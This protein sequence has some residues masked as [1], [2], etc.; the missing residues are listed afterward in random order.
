[1]RTPLSPL[2]AGLV[3]ALGGAA[4]GATRSSAPPAAGVDAAATTAPGVLPAAAAVLP[5]AAPAPVAG[6]WVTADY[7]RPVPDAAYASPSV[8]GV[9]LRL[10]WSEVHPSSTAY[11]WAYLDREIDRARAAGKRVS[12]AL[13]AG[14]FTPAWVYDAGVPRLRFTEIPHDGQAETCATFDNP[15]PWAPAF[16]EAF[17]RA[18]AAL[19]EHLRARPERLAAVAMV[20]LTGIN[21][22]TAETRMPAQE[23]VSNARCTTTDAPAI[24]LAAGYRPSLVRGAFRA[25]SDALAAAFPDKVLSVAVIPRG[26]P[27]ISEEGERLAEPTQELTGSLVEAGVAAYGRRFAVQWNALRAGFVVPKIIGEARR[28][29]ALVGLQLHHGEF[30]QPACSS[31]GAAPCDEARMRATIDLGLEHGMTFLEIFPKDVDAYP[32]ALAY[33]RARLE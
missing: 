7:G 4:C 17:G 33:A 5:V 28:K 8:T 16:V 2:V 21:E 24:W 15:P 1:M 31:P 6:V 13:M 19:G 10:R 32:E 26:F 29:G 23:V 12:V 27:A 14:R 22:Q 9:F 30:G 11:D 3:A 20:K 25:L 18:A